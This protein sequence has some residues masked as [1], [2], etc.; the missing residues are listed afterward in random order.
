MTNELAHITLKGRI[1]LHL[2]VCPNN[3]LCNGKE[4]GHHALFSAMFRLLHSV[5]NK[6]QYEKHLCNQSINEVST[7][8]TGD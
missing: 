4:G 2:N 6:E 1:I 8:N 7:I 5:T 3:L